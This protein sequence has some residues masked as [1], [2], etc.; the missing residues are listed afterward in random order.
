MR[1]RQAATTLAGIRLDHLYRYLYAQPMAVSPVLD[2][3]CGVGYG[4][5]ILAE[6]GNYVTAV[7]IDNAA[8]AYGQNYYAHGNIQWIRGDILDRPWSWE[9]FNT[10]LSFETLEHLKE[11]GVALRV[12]WDSLE[13]G[14][15]LIC[16]VPNQEVYPFKAEN[17]AGETYPH[18]RHYT[19]VELNDLL[20]DCGFEVIHRG[21][22]L[23][24]T[25]TVHTGS[26]G[27][28]LVYTANK[29]KKVWPQ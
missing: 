17:F 28:F 2:A 23:T 24:K 22:Q 5:Y 14:G 27:M 15:K 16:S 7:D 6:H 9:R 25:S 4:A 10:I 11:P 3:A 18:Q 26:G 1:D 12:F 21:T 19:S 20:Y 13:D 8:I 29:R